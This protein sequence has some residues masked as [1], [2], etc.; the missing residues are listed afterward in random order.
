MYLFIFKFHENDAAVTP[1]EYN[2][3]E[4]RNI[5]EFTHKNC[6]IRYNWGDL[7]K[8]YFNLPSLGG[9]PPEISFNHGEVTV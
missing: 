5:H 4:A 3:C 6:Q 7:I 8:Y 9:P 2:Y 1:A